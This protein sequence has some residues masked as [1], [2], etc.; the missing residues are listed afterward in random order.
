MMSIFGLS[1]CIGPVSISSRCGRQ[2]PGRED[3]VG[4]GAPERRISTERLSRLRSCGRP[5]VHHELAVVALRFDDPAHPPGL[6]VSVARPRHVHVALLSPPS[7]TPKF[8]LWRNLLT[9]VSLSLSL[10]LC[11]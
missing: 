2:C 8:Q 5:H 10:S 7:H 6:H 4:A 9:M 11:R 3:L 1:S